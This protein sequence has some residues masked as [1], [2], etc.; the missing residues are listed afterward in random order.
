ME[1][2]EPKFRLTGYPSYRILRHK[3]AENFN[4]INP[5]LKGYRQTDFVIT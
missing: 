3:L 4:Y 1:N 2:A 5:G